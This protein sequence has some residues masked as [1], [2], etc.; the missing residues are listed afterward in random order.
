MR[1]KLDSTENPRS[2]GN[3]QP[4]LKTKK[5]K[6]LEGET[7]AREVKPPSPSTYDMYKTCS[8]LISDSD[9]VIDRVKG[10]GDVL[11]V[12]EGPNQIL[13]SFCVDKIKHCSCFE[14]FCAD[15]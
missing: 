1:C 9:R 11:E 12:E 7:P 8:L 2:F 10:A 4:H 6:E 14:M 15:N 3:T 5:I 13:S